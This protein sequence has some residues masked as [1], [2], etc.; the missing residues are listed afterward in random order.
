MTTDLLDV[1]I[2]TRGGDIRKMVLLDYA[3]TADKP[4]VKLA[5]MEDND[6]NYFIAQSGL[7]SSDAIARRLTTHSIPQI[8]TATH[9]SQAAMWLKCPAL[10]K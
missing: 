4:D 7:V 2:D 6:D 3:K 1:E 9:Y 5:L 10:A 8:K